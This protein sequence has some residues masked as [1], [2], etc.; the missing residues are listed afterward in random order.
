MYVV[1]CKNKAADKWHCHVRMHETQELADKA[2]D[3]HRREFPGS[4]TC[5]RY[6]ACLS[7]IEQRAKGYANAS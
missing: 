2:A 1:L 3:Y 4:V 5:V 6:L 7:D